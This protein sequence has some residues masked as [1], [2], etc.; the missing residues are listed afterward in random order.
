[1]HQ[2]TTRSATAAALFALALSACGGGSA[3][4]EEAQAEQAAAE[5][6]AADGF[7]ITDPW[8]KA[9]T[10]D[11]GMTGVFGE[12]ANTS[13]SEMTIVSA[14]ADGADTVELHEVAMEGT[15]TTMTE[16]E[17][18]FVI[19]AGETY[20]LEPGGYHIMLMQ[21]TRDLAAGNELTVT[22]EFADGSTASFDAPIRPYTGANEEYEGGSEGGEEHDMGDMEGDHSGQGDG[23]GEDGGD[24]GDGYGDE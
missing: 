22:V 17:G 7:E 4:P 21:L 12:I 15:D 11:E 19:P 5:A 3:E 16:V 8:V 10:Q 20:T 18:G 23:S 9:V 6:T 2:R 1:M 13:A 14:T 24:S